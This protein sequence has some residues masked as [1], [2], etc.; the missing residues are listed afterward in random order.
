MTSI[1][2]PNWLV[3]IL[4]LLLG[5]LNVLF[6]ALQLNIIQQG[7]PAVPDEFV[8]MQYFATP[9]PIVLHIVSG[10]I[11]NLM[12]PFQ[13]ARTFRRRWPAWHRWSGRLLLISGVLAA[14]SALW[15]NHFFPAYGGMLKYTGIVV[16]SV[17]MI[18]AFGLSLRLVLSGDIPR[19]RSWMMRAIAFGLGPATQRLF[20]L[21]YFFAF[22]IPSDLVIGV[23]VWLGFVLN[24]A[25]VEWVLMR[26]HR[27][28]RGKVNATPEMATA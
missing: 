11:L 24:L 22:G 8:S 7:P 12:A 18:V 2:K 21:P 20:I 13:F 10:I 28:R 25:V 15:M 3:P 9:I 4:L 6:G 1:Q 23:V 19:H 27:D 16:N 5:G 14:L 17:G 26:E